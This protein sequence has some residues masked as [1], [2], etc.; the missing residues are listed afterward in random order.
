MLERLDPR[1]IPSQ[2]VILYLAD[3]VFKGYEALT[4]L[5]ETLVVELPKVDEKMYLYGAQ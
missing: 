4:I 3:Y 5:W 1:E 2:E